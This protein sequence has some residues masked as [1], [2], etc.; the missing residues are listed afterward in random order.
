MWLYRSKLPEAINT[1]E[2][3]YLWCFYQLSTTNEKVEIEGETEFIIDGELIRP[4]GV[5]E[6]LFL[7]TK[8]NLPIDENWLINKVKLWENAEEINPANLEL[9]YCEKLTGYCSQDLSVLPSISFTPL[10]YII[11]QIGYCEQNLSLL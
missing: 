3:L 2:K 7:A 8:I 1:V 11:E 4:D 5:D 10:V 6:R 9:N